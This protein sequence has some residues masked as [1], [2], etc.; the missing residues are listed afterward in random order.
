MQML[1]EWVNDYEM[2][3]MRLCILWAGSR[4]FRRLLPL[5]VPL[6]IGLCWRRRLCCCRCCSQSFFVCFSESSLIFFKL[7]V[8]S[9]HQ[10]FCKRIFARFPQTPRFCT[11][12]G[13]FCKWL[14][15]G[16]G[17]QRSRHSKSTISSSL[18]FHA[19]FGLWSKSPELTT[20]CIF[21]SASVF[22]LK[23]FCVSGL[24]SFVFGIPTCVYFLLLLLF[25]KCQPGVVQW[26]KACVFF[27]LMLVLL[28]GSWS[29]CSHFGIFSSRKLS[30]LG[31]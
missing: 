29:C 31:P 12:F 14:G 22:F 27:G 19:R 23:I 9:L 26:A 13:E 30:F 4:P 2:E 24:V 10:A 21:F 6:W 28:Y 3:W 18:R 8:R 1:S 20:V 15:G 25:E 7:S 11:S 16:G 5:S 17:G